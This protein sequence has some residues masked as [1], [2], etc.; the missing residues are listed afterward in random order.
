MKKILLSLVFLSITFFVSAQ[1]NDNLLAKQ[2]VTGNA[3]AIG[4]SQNDLD[5]Y[6]VSSSYFNQNAGTQM[7]YLQQTV[8]YYRC[9]AYD[10]G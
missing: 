1:N 6:F 2:L 5:N 10:D 3:A 7:L 9:S 4:L 8:R